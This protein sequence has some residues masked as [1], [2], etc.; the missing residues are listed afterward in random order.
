MEP[1]DQ[2]LEDGELE[3]PSQP[4][5]LNV[6][7]SH[8]AMHGTIRIVMELSGENIINADVQIW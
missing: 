3:L 2:E 8:P 6:G 1:I 5:M 7:P 4:M